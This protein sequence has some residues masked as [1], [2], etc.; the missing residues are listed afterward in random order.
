MSSV[1]T[2]DNG[3]IRIITINRPEAMNALDLPTVQGIGRAL[4]E[5]DEDPAVRA[6]VLTSAGDR[7][8]SV[9]LDLKAFTADPDAFKSFDPDFG[10]FLAKGLR[11]PVIGAAPG[12][13]VGGGLEL[14]LACDLILL[15]EHAKIGLPEVKRG[16]FASGG[17]TRISTR[18][19]IALAMEV[20]LTGD[21]LLAHR[22]YEMGLANRVVPLAD[23]RETS[24]A[25]AGAVAAN[26][27]LAV[28]T[29]KRLLLNALEV[30]RD[31]AW[32]QIQTAWKIV[33]ESKDAAEG[34]AAF[35]ERREPR[36]T[37]A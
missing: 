15:A 17:G 2:E 18:I 29:T 26:G 7:A 35:I 13:A 12:A 37:G 20:A 6:I 27:P 22:A 24:L 10:A 19:P 1:L 34:T 16:L 8:F 3:A 28:T 32:E 23:L 21:L 11:T 36:W 14:L 9:G 30:D 25:L 33:H 31:E 5:A 4:R